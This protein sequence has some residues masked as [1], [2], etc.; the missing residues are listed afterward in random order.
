MRPMCQ[1]SVEGHVL[2]AVKMRTQGSGCGE[3]E[4]G[5]DQGV[6][7]EA[8]FHRKSH[9]RGQGQRVQEHGVLGA[10]WHDACPHVPLELHEL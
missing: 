3:R 4:R 7:L 6:I 2:E 9:F 1:W 5:E 10:G 8:L